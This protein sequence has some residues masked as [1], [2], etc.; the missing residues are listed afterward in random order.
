MQAYKS[1]RVQTV[2]LW[3]WLSPLIYRYP[4]CSFLFAPCKFQSC[5]LFLQFIRAEGFIFS[6]VAD[7]GMLDACAGQLMRYRKS[8]ALENNVLV[9]TDLKV[10]LFCALFGQPM[11]RVDQTLFLQKKH[12]SHAITS[13]LDII[14]TAKAAEFFLSDGVVL[15]G[16]RTGSPASKHELKQVLSAVELP[17]I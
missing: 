8:L 7:E 9:F 12:S 15:T 14:D 2:R 10:R 4:I 17:G 3:L 5:Q 11:K 6:H 16:S 1:W 13:D